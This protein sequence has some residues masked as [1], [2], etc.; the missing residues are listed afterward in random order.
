MRRR[1]AGSVLTY[2]ETPTPLNLARALLGRLAPPAAGDAVQRLSAGVDVVEL[3]CGRGS[4]LL[5]LA[6]AFPRSRFTGL[7]RSSDA[8]AEAA[9][10]AQ[11]RRLD[12]VVFRR[13]EDRPAPDLE[14]FDVVI[15]SGSVTWR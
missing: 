2:Y 1:Y 12:N 14:S 15:S 7:D 6:A 9:R 8:I 4:A 5:T 13:L 3:G 11:L 10:L